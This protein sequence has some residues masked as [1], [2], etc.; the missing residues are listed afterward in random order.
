M[1][2]IGIKPEINPAIIGKLDPG[3]PNLCAA[4]HSD[5]SDNRINADA[6]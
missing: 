5:G 6:I 4:A 2:D 3:M 1:A